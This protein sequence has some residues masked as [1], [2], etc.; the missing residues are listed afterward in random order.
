MVRKSA[1]IVILGAAI[2][3]PALGGCTFQAGGGANAGNEPPPPPPATAEPAPAP[4]PT[5]EP[6]PA[7]AQTSTATVKGDSVNIPGNIVFDNNKA[8]LKA[9]AGSEEVLTQLKK[10]LDENPQVTKLRIEGHTDNVGQP[11][12]NMT[13]SGAR[14]LTIKQ[15]LITNGVPAERLIAVGF[16]ETRPV[17]DNGTADGKAQNRRSEFKIA[18]LGGKKYL[19]QPVDGGGQEFK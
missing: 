4:A 14:A 11:A 18:E 17:A 5:V 2:S 8:T 16:G 1:W 7:P 6:A 9:G 13:L 19:N 12:A 3:A 15:W 10:F